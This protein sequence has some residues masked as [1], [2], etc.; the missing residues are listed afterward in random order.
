MNVAFAVAVIAGIS[1]A[2]VLM[3]TFSLYLLVEIVETVR[4]KWL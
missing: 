3:V 1:A 2:A 4:M